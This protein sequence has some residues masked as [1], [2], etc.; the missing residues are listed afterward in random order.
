MEIVEGIHRID[1]ASANMAHSNVYLIINK[2]GLIVIDTG[3]S[4]NG[5]KIVDYIQKIG[6]QPTEVVFIVLTHFHMDHVGSAKELKELL[7]NA[8]IAAHEDEA[9]YISGKKPCLNQKTSCLG[10]F[11][12]L[13]NLSLSQSTS[14]LRKTRKLQTSK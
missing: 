3:T 10:P 14:F 9:E 7:P 4:G 5:K 2:N 13:S 11:P 6:H 8:K 12:L 1:G